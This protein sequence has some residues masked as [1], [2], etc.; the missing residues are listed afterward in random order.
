MGG[1]G[2]GGGGRVVV[3]AQALSGVKVAN[4]F[5]MFTEQECNVHKILL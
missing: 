2:G 3:V 4:S 5:L 1:G